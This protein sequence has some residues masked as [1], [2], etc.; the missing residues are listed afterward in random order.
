[1]SPRLLSGH[2]QGFLVLPAGVDLRSIRMEKHMTAA[3]LPLYSDHQPPE[4][5]GVTKEGSSPATE[6]GIS[7]FSAS[8]AQ[9][10]FL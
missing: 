1:M 9:W 5:M 6:P 10:N 2:T 3:P 8:V 7:R 4:R